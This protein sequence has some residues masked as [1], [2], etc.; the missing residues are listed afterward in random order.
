LEAYIAD[1]SNPQH[2]PAGMKG[3]WAV[4]EYGAGSSIY[5]HAENPKRQDHSEEYEA[6]LHENT[7]KVFARHPEIWG[8]FVWSMFDFAVDGRA[9]GEAA[10]GDADA[11]LAGWPEFQSARYLRGIVNFSLG[12]DAEAVADWRRL[13]EADATWDT[14]EVRSW[15][16]RAEGRLKK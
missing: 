8:K 15:I 14:P 5:F 9:E 4:T 11:A 7:W 16:Q 3:M 2:N 13:L 6:L 12:R 10:L 1:H